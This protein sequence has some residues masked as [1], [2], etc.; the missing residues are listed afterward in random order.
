MERGRTQPTSMAIAVS[1]AAIAGAAVFY[2][3]TLLSLKRVDKMT[4][5]CRTMRRPCRM[6][7]HHREPGEERS[8]SKDSLVRMWLSNFQRTLKGHGLRRTSPALH[9]TVP[10]HGPGEAST[11]GCSP[12][13]RT[14]SCTF[15]YAAASTCPTDRRTMPSFTSLSARVIVEDDDSSRFTR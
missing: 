8:T 7:A 10:A 4:A 15:G 12:I 2:Q 13:L 9:A 11:S 14:R 1:S 6:D 3:R 5:L